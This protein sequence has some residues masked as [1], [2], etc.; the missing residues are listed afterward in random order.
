MN[1]LLIDPKISTCDILIK[2]LFPLGVTVFQRP[3]ISC[4]LEHVAQ[5]NYNLLLVDIDAAPRESLLFLTE[6]GKLPVKPVRM[7]LSSI[8][9]K[10]LITALVKSGIAAY[11]LKP[12]SEEKA[13]P[14]IMDIIGRM[15][16]GAE[17]RKY[18]RVTP[19]QEEETRVFLRLV[20]N[21]RLISGTLLNISAGGLAVSAHEELSDEAMKP[22]DF[23]QKIQFKLD[24]QDL[25]LSGK[26]V[27]KKANVFAISFQK[28]SEADLFV[29][30]KYIFRKISE[31]P[32]H[33]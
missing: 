24:N 23:I 28:C 4:G 2:K 27:F 17:L 33:H 21:P 15:G 8:T 31:A 7:V 20:G 11:F 18:Y 25:G 5:G 9:D 26:V 3:D 10:N 12:F 16:S 30:S 29:V 14:K 19:G 32:E 22:G 13:I 1:L 6:A